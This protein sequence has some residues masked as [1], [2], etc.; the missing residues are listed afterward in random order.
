MKAKI[1]SHIEKQRL[2]YEIAG[3]IAIKLLIITIIWHLFFSHPIEESLSNKQY[4][5]HFFNDKSK[6][7]P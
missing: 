7:T 1:K 6:S 4:Q 3:S 2:R 5:Q